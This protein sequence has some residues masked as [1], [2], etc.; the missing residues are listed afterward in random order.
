MC[1][2]LFLLFPFN[3]KSQIQQKPEVTYDTAIRTGPEKPAPLPAP[4]KPEIKK[5]GNALCSCVIYLEKA[6]GFNP[7][8]I[9][10]ASNWPINAKF[11]DIGEVIVFSYPAHVSYIIGFTEKGWIV[12]ESN[13]VSCTHT[14]DRIVPYNDPSI[15][16][17]WIPN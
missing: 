9:G 16:G 15:K 14:D 5:A 2:V 4:A 11:G 12:D 7:G 13:W 17:Y 1:L 3:V 6:Y 10:L 8:V